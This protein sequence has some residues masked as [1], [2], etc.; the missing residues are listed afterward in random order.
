MTRQELRDWI[1]DQIR[2][3]A[4]SFDESS[5]FLGLTLNGVRVG[6]MP[7]AGEDGVRF[8]YM[9][10]MRAGIEGARSRHD[11]AEVKRLEA[12]L[13]TMLRKQGEAWGAIA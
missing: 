11:P 13:Q 1:N 2:S 9:Q 12:A 6:E 8:D 10:I 7:P 3:G 5:A 4:M